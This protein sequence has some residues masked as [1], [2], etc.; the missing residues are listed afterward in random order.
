[1]RPMMMLMGG[2]LLA[3]NL[4]LAM[5]LRVAANTFRSSEQAEREVRERMAEHLCERGIEPVAAREI[6][7]RATGKHPERFVRQVHHFAALFP[8][9]GREK[10]LAYGASE[11]LRGRSV[12]LGSYDAVVSALQRLLPSPALDR[13]ERERA[14]H[15]VMMNRMAAAA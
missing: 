14:V 15:C 13:Y 1:M 6:V 10:L 9:I 4:V 7:A 2:L 5:P 3:G 8:E 12:D 11:A